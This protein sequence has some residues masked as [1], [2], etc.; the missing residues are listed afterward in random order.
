M[1]T[2][3]LRSPSN[4]DSSSSA[5]DPVPWG[6]D[7]RRGMEMNLSD[8]QDHVFRGKLGELQADY[9]LA[10]LLFLTYTLVK[11]GQNLECAR[12]YL[13]ENKW[14]DGDITS[15]SVNSLH[16]IRNADLREKV[17]GITESIGTTVWWTAYALRVCNGSA[18]EAS[19][20]LTEGVIDATINPWESG[21]NVDTDDKIFTR[22]AEVKVETSKIKQEPKALGSPYGS[23]ALG[24]WITPPITPN[25][26]SNT[27]RMKEGLPFMFKSESKSE[28]DRVIDESSD[29]DITLSSIMNDGRSRS[30]SPSTAETSDTEDRR[31]VKISQMRAIFPHLTTSQCMTSLELS[32]GDVSEAINLE[33]E[34]L[35]EESVVGDSPRTPPSPSSSAAVQPQKRKS[36]TPVRLLHNIQVLN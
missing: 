16:A 4:V 3:K 28:T 19:G 14:V 7:G 1:V 5:T 21:I 8:V 11:T 24:D 32:D 25:D 2:L 26:V 22:S 31:E 36:S 6:R 18:N 29:D 30:I 17:R 20:L 35:H 33:L 10:P 23:P 9:P 12:I 13:R 34:N 27:D 15:I